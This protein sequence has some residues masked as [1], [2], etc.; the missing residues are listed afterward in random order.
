LNGILDLVPHPGE[1]KKET[2]DADFEEAFQEDVQRG[3]EDSMTEEEEGRGQGGV[4]DG[5][6]EALGVAGNLRAQE[7]SKGAK[8]R[9]GHSHI[10]QT[11]VFSATLT[12]PGEKRKRLRK[13]GGGAGGGASLENLMDR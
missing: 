12:L 5:E 13:G 4:S 3:K 11:F 10:L 1:A 2:Y 9:K 8:R 6:E 7:S